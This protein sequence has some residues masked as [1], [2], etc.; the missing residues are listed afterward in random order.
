MQRANHGGAIEQSLHERQA[1]NIRGDVAVAFT[2]SQPGFSLFKLSTAEIQQGHLGVT[3]VARGVTTGT[4]AQLQQAATGGW[5][6]ALERHGFTAIFIIAPT[7]FPETGLVIGAFIIAYWGCLHHSPESEKCV[8]TGLPAAPRLS[9]L[10]LLPLGPDGVRRALP[11][12]S[13]PE[14]GVKDTLSSA[15]RQRIIN[16]ILKS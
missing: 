5:Q 13:H 16:P 7:F 6:Q 2:C 10:P 11:R 8:R 1:V 9:S 4:R 3:T 15:L 14:R 12:R